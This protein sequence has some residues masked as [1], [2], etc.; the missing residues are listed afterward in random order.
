MS[1]R[2]KGGCNSVR[3]VVEPGAGDSDT[4]IFYGS[5]EVLPPGGETP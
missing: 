1:E 2:F 3:R 5:A 4:G